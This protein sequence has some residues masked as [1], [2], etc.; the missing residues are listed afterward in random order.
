MFYGKNKAFERAISKA[1]YDKE[2]TQLE[3]KQTRDEEGGL[4][5]PQITKGETFN[6]NIA[7]NHARAIEEFGQTTTATAI[8]TTSTK[9]NLKSGQKLQHKGK[10]YII[11]DLAIYDTH[12]K[13]GLKEWKSKSEE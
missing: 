6:G 2:I 10:N 7:T 1:F 12:Q 9:V 11:T 4:T 13:V 8:L 3:V 5:R